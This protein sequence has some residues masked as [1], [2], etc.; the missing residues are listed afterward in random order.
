VRK[1]GKKYIKHYTFSHTTREKRRKEIIVL[2]AERLIDMMIEN[3]LL[4]TQ[5]EVA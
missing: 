3:T 4:K 2:I 5:L 1:S